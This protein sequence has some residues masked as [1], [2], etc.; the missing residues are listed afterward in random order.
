MP[1]QPGPKRPT[2]LI[3]ED[4]RHT[5]EGYSH[6]LSICGVNTVEAED[7]LHGLARATSILPD[8]ISTDLSLPRMNGIELCR[9][10][11]QEERT[12]HIPV[13][14]LTGSTSENEVE[15]AR[16]AGCILVLMKP[17]APSK[18]LEEILRVLDL[19][20]VR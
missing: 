11:K 7:G 16:K 5:R 2:A 18:L 20:A 10:L 4:D 6:Y 13:I 12:R 19:P 17:C 9:S 14:V 8:V 3:V 15:A 1:L